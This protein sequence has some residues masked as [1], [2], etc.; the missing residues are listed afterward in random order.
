MTPAFPAIYGGYFVGFG[1]IYTHNDLAL[2]P[3]VWASRVAASF[4]WGIQMG[5]F[6]LGGVDH[7]PDV[8]TQCGP[9]HTLDAFL[10]PKHDEEVDYLRLLATARGSMSRYFVHGRLGSPV[11]ITPTPTVFMAPNQTIMPGN[12]G[13]FPTLSHAVWLAPS[14]NNSS[15]SN[16]GQ[17][18]SPPASLCLFLVTS[19]SAAVPVSAE[20]RMT[21]YGFDGKRF[22]VTLVAPD[23]TSTHVATVDDG[24]VHVNRTVAGRHIEMLEVKPF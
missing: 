22:A 11:T 6:S 14:Q 17:S 18:A 7:G 12:P 23:G 2:N 1:S 5:W 20:L 4:V 16:R 15:I 21:L 10:D 8:D 3:D 13:P 9:M 19:T 24:V